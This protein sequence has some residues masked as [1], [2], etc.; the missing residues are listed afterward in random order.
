[1]R[2][3]Q[4]AAAE[5]GMQTKLFHLSEDI[6]EANLLALIDELNGDKDIN[7]IIVQF[8]RRKEP[9]QLRLMP[10]RA[11]IAVAAH[12]GKQVA[13]FPDHTEVLT[14]CDDLVC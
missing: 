11:R 2:N 6:S 13:V 7:G 3:K 12:L 1:M 10:G 14:A 5:I 9:I 8:F 4:K